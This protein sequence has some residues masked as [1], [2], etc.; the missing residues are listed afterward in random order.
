M[1]RGLLHL[2]AA[3]GPEAG[4]RALQKTVLHQ[5]Q[6]PPD[7]LKAAHLGQQSNSKHWNPSPQ[8]LIPGAS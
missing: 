1:M 4:T 7:P 3:A 8:T 2:A 5:M 6:Q